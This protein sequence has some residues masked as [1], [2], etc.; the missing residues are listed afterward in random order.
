MP[1]VTGD[2]YPLGAEDVGM[3][4]TVRVTVQ[5][6]AGQVASRDATSSTVGV[7]EVVKTHLTEWSVRQGERAFAVLMPSIGDK[8]GHVFFNAEKLKVQDKS[9]KKTLHKDAFKDVTMEM[10]TD[11][12]GRLFTLHMKALV[13]QKPRGE[14]FRAKDRVERD[15]IYLTLQ[16]FS[17]NPQWL[18]RLPTAPGGVGLPIDIASTT[19]SG[20]STSPDG[21][22]SPTSSIASGVSGIGDA[23]PSEV[24]SQQ[25]KKVSGSR[26]FSFGRKKK[27]T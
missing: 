18:G 6:P 2:S 15:L 7:P 10:G 22:P 16:A 21:P 9:R 17:N 3:E 19:L 4:V 13:K 26:T 23:P 11:D 20:P 1:H 5:G 25:G 8:E 14:Q 27:S 12:E 24:G